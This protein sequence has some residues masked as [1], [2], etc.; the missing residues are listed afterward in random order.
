MTRNRASAKSAGS[1]FER[2][3]ADYLAH[4]LD[5]D[6]IDRRVKNGSNDRGDITGVRLHGSR[7]VIECKNESSQRIP[8][9]LREAEVERGNDDAL[10]GIVVTKRRGVG[11]T[12]D[13]MG[14]QLVCMTLE[15]L[16]VLIAGDREIIERKAGEK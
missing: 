10:A 7:V 9:Y 2:A 3:V 1:R 4:V 12:P 13:S 14:E 6:R 11:M 15:T 16:A 8:A 5:D